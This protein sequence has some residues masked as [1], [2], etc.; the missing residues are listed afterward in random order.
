MKREEYRDCMGKAMKGITGISREERGKLFCVNAKLCSG[1]SKTR[2]EAERVCSLPKP[3]KAPKAKRATGQSCEKEVL[4]LS[5]CMVDHIDMGM[6]SNINSVGAAIA[7]A[8]MRCRC[9]GQE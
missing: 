1:K 2:E 8:M 4:G 5:Q 9:P 6:A 3:P 7:N